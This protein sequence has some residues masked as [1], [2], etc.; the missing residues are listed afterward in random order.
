MKNQIL[1]T[2]IVLFMAPM[3][4]IAAETRI[5]YISFKDGQLIAIPE[6]F[7]LKETNHKGNSTLTLEG[8]NTFTYDENEIIGVGYEYPSTKP[9]LISFEFTTENNDQVYAN[10]HANILERGDT[11]DIEANVPVIGKRLR[12]SFTLSKEAVLYFDDEEQISGFS[13][14][15]FDGPFSYTLANSNHWIYDAKVIENESNNNQTIFDFYP[16]GRTC[17]VHINYLTDFAIKHNKI[18]TI[19]ITF[20]DGKTWD[21]TQWIGQTLP[22]GSNTKNTWIKDCTFRLDG[23]GVWPNIETIEGCEIRGRGNTSWSYSYMSKNPYR[24]KFPKKQKQGPFN[25]TEDRQWVLIAN[26]KG[27]SM[28]TNSIAQKIAAMVDAES[29]CHMIPIELYINGHYRGSYCFTEKIGIADNSVAI[30]ETTGC[31]LELDSYF[32]EAYKFRD[33]TYDLPINIKDPDFSEEDEKRI[34]TLDNIQSSFNDLTSSVKN[35]NNIPSRL[36]MEAWAKFWLVNDLVYNGETAHPKSC[37]VFNPN[38]AEG[39]KWFFGPAWD[40]DWACGYDPTTKKYF[41]VGSTAYL[42]GCSF[43]RDIRKSEVGKRAYYKEWEDF[44]NEGRV[45]EL[46]EYIDD[47][48]EFALP[49]F[50]HNNDANIREKDSINY[51]ELA[52]CSKEWIKKRANYIYSKLESFNTSTYSL[53]DSIDYEFYKEE[54]FGIIT[55]SR[56]LPNLNWNSL[57]VPF[58]I[59]VSSIS[60]RYEVAYINEVTPFDN[61]GDRVIDN[62]TMGVIKIQTGTLEANRPYLIK[63]KTEADKKINITV[64]DQT[65]FEANENSIDYSSNYVTA[66]I[67]GSYTRKSDKELNGAL[68]ISTKDTWNPINEG[69]CLNPFRLYLTI[70]EH[71]N[72][73]MKVESS[74][75]SQIKILVHED[76]TTIESIK[77]EYKNIQSTIYDLQGRRVYKPKKGQLYIVN[78]DKIVF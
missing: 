61:N 46:I 2:L 47:Y 74:A 1:F 26:K 41:N 71:D 17:K 73:P 69:T 40:F 68:I 35:N 54:E 32:D 25:L 75:L 44:M 76:A 21:E 29:L 66:K 59:P 5:R 60:D 67:Y 3:N 13:S 65:L 38:P 10:V 62:I 31:L 58:E 33:D 63:A 22:D 16:L 30:D 8:D 6:I 27:G 45:Q 19:Y 18:P 72:S 15:R 12:P 70:S 36:D 39:E 52:D 78:G 56:M 51:L 14:H 42:Y 11:I 20:G 24:I 23:A 55:Y 64:Y 37:Y 28:T 50:L 53:I 77:T 49:S 9:N 7:I 48:T 4:N 43:F 57:Y 34:I